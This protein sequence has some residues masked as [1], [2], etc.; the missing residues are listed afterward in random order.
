MDPTLGQNSSVSSAGRNG[1]ES[2]PS[3][4]IV[5]S[6]DVSAVTAADEATLDGLARL[7]LVARRLGVSIEFRHA[8]RELVDLLE[9]VGLAGELTVEPLGQAE[10]REQ[11]RIDEEIDPGDP[12]VGDLQD[13][14]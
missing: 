5:V 8:R 12:P 10:Q 14:D 13:M 7:L 9:L 3:R 2:V 1:L 4:R 6:Y 11:V